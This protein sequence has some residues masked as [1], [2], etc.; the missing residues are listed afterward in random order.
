MLSKNLKAHDSNGKK[1]KKNGCEFCRTEN[2]ER[3]IPSRTYL[4]VEAASRLYERTRARVSRNLKMHSR[5]ILEISPNWV[6]K[7]P[8]FSSGLLR[9]RR[10][11][12]SD[13]SFPFEIA[14]DVLSG[15]RS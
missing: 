9:D 13:F 5:D 11:R 10:V 7:Y 14:I 6:E 8:T 15:Q 12:P 1:K 3:S 4:V 2:Q